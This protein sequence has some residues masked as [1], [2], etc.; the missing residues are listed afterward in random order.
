MPVIPEGYGIHELTPDDAPGLAAAY[1]RNRAHLEPWE[2]ARE[3]SFFTEDG[4]AAAVAGQLTTVASGLNAAWVLTRGDEV[5]GRVNLNN[6]VRG[7]L[8]SASVG[9]WIDADHQGR[10]LATGAVEVACAQAE[11]RGLHR[12]QAGTLPHNLASQRVLE[13]SGFA[14][15]GTADRYLYIAG[16][17]RPH[18]L[19]QRILNDEPL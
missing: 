18:R 12:V 4:Q 8:C 7:V 2:P 11:G 1:A 19:Y 5:V 16:A 15:Y 6:I 3:E 17:W 14:Y 10:G 13:R 9:Y